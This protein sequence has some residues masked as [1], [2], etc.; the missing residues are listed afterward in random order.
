MEEN[1]SAFCDRM[2][3]KYEGGYGWDKGDSGGP[4][5]FGITCY[6]L[7]AHRGQKMDSM[8]RW[9]PIV[10]AMA[11]VVKDTISGNVYLAYN[12]AGAIATANLTAGTIASQALIVTPSANISMSCNQSANPSPNTFTYTLS[13]SSGNVNYSITGLPGWLP[14][15]IPATGS[16]TT[17]GTTATFTASSAG[18]SPN[19]YNATITFTNTTNGQ[20][21][22]TRLVALT[23]AASAQPVLQLTPITDITTSGNPGGP[24][25]PTQ[26]TYQLSTTQGTANFSITGIPNWL[27]CSPRTGNVGTTGTTISFQTNSGPNP[28]GAGT[29]PSTIRFANTDTGAGTTTRNATVTVLAAAP[30]L[31]V[32]P[33]VNIV[34]S[35]DQGGPFTPNLFTYT[36]KSQSGTINW[37]ISGC[38]SWLTPSATSGAATTTGSQVSLTVN[39]NSQAVGNYPATITF[40]NSD[41]GSGTT[42]RAATL[43]V[44]TV[45]TPGALPG[46][47]L[48]HWKMGQYN[49]A[50][51]QSVAN[52][53]AGAGTKA[54]SLVLYR[55]Q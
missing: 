23:V 44:T 29:Y 22:A 35:G 31:V 37:V 33:A 51:N 43:T 3:K 32:T 7:A 13:S 6:D 19:T 27:E 2:I 46:N 45:A 40:T 1:Y 38:P 16:V 42:T 53:V 36:I 15:S 28:L 10:Y 50:A 14:L 34:T 5:K 48:G 30:A 47:P 11:A 20:G 26:W 24:F 52:I 54:H 49:A 41:T 9:A 12:D 21:N 39:A 55:Y 18:L 25:S 17:T 4:T 8:K